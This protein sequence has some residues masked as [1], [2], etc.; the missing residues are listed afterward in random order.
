MIPA[1]AAAQSITGVVRDTSGA[2]LPGVT[3]EAA[4]PALI[5]KLRTAVTDDSGQ[6]RLENLTPGLYK[7][8]YTLPGFNIVEREGVQVSTG[9]T[10]TL[11][12]DLRVGGLQETI[13]V[14]GDTPVV[15]VQNSTRVQRVLSD[16]VLAALPASRGYGNL[17]TTVS[18]IQANATQ[19]GGVNPGMIF[20][21]SR[22][23]RSN[24]G[25]IQIDGMNVGSAFNGGGVAGYGYDT[26][27]AQEVQVTVAGGLGEADRGGPQFNIVPKTGGNT[28]S[29]TYFGSLAGEWSQG[30][31]VDDVLR[32][33]GIPAPTK[34]I[35]N[36]D[37]SFSLGG[38]IM[39]DRVWFYAVARTFG[40]YTDIA[41]RF[42]N[43]NAG[44]PTRW[45]YVVDQSIKSRSA[46]SR[47]IAGTR[48]TGQLSDRNKVSAYYD[49]QYICSGSSYAKDA[50]ACRVRGDDWV[51]VYGFGTWSPEASQKQDGGEH[52]M[53]FSYTAPMTSKLLL[54]AAFSQFFSNWSPT[55]PAGALNTE[56]FIPVQERS[57]AGG[58]P[59]PNMVYHGYAGLNNNHQT[60]NVW[61]A[62]VAYVTGAHS[63]K[64]GYQAA[65]EVTDIFG[66]FASHGLQYRFNAGAP[67]Q[68]TQR[69]TRWQQANRTRWDAF[70]VQD[71]WTRNRL[72]LQGALRYE[73]ARSFFP[74]GINGL[75]TDSVFGGPARTLPRA[76]GVTGYN[77][78]APRMGMAYDVFG[79][80]RT[81]IKANLSKYWQYAAN[82]GVYIGTNPAS[83]FAQTANRAWTDANGNFTPNCDLQNPLAQDNRAGGG[84]FC[85]ALDN[86]NFFVFRQTGSALST[87]TQ[88]DPALLS[89]WGVRPYDWQFSASVQ[90]ELMPRVSAEIGFSRRW[91]GNFTV[92]DNRAIGPQDFDSYTFT[93]PSD[94][95]LAASGQPVTYLLRN[96]RTPFG[97]VDNYLTLADNYGNLEAYWQGVEMTVNARVNTGLTVQGGFTSGAGTRDLCDITPQVPE[98]Y[99]TTGTMLLNTG[100]SP[101]QQVSACRVEEPWLWSWRGLASY[102]VPKVDVQVSAI[103]RSQPNI[104][105]TNDPASNGLA[106]NATFF[107]TNAAVQAA[108]GRPIAGGAPTVALN[109]TKPGEVYPDRLNTVDMRFTKIL[110]FGRTRTNVGV[111]LYNLF[112]ANTGT[113]F[114]E[115]Y[116]TDG[117]AWLRP[118]A[119][120][121][122]RYVRFN[123]TMDF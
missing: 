68:I 46:S 70:Y 75:L 12:A 79:N 27:N 97:A 84:D 9:V 13:T 35:R 30:N 26:T 106:A 40:E 62:S 50:D 49:Y 31:N 54:E 119:I 53:Q 77:D 58:V 10:L 23:G 8:T 91:W 34:I 41:G 74:E 113:G 112:N 67:D 44:D 122:P 108:L 32:S 48:V 6:F 100:N 14:T 66:D 69:I 29:G 98:L 61:R 19:N 17:L 102:I 7:V 72:T 88:I 111:D 115:N 56:P 94:P 121:N 73:H 87:A 117:S 55:S 80:G 85:G 71:Q 51:A 16:E 63:M 2:V 3:V 39:R 118:N 96:N 36:W 1:L 42:G 4:S 11:N 5:E 60:H 109:L 81:A 110:R 92:T 78:I 103:M 123:V 20:F 37:T 89:G 25:T 33:Y 95:R 99:Y 93:A 83:T 15:D 86:Q 65:Y 76:D 105:A 82:D 101:I 116:G 104:T 43:L 52:I 120:L 47:K 64:V 107:Q 18:G 28:F 22:G 59:V 21:T 24:E 45:N 38:P 57:L 90:Q 114:N